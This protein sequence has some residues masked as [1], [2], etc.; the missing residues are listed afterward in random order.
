VSLAPTSFPRRLTIP[1][2]RLALDLRR[3]LGFEAGV[4][5]SAADVAKQ[6][7]PLTQRTPAA[8]PVVKAKMARFVALG[9]AVFVPG[10]RGGSGWA[11][12]PQGADLARASQHWKH[13]SVR[14]AARR[15]GRP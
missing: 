7:S 15:R 1:T 10:V 6:L 11:L 8:G 4:R 9:L 14:G 13:P 2:Y 12:T 5:L 3:Y